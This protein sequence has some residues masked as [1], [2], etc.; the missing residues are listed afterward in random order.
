MPCT[1]RHLEQAG[2]NQTV[3]PSS[4]TAVPPSARAGAVGQLEVLGLGV[5][6]LEGVGPLGLE[7]GGALLLEA[8]LHG[9]GRLLARLHHLLGLGLVLGRRAQL[10]E[11]LE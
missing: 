9:V 11:W 1:V 10:A 8:V 7:E 4:L 6:V 2:L 5:E 3:T